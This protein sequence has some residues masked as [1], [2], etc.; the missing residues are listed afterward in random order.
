MLKPH[1]VFAWKIA[2]TTLDHALT[3]HDEDGA[4]SL[5]LNGGDH[6]LE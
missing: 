4:Q 5:I 3:A 2:S 6:V 1:N